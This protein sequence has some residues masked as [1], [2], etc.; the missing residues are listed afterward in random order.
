MHRASFACNRRAFLKLAGVGTAALAFSAGVPI[1]LGATQLSRGR[2]PR[3][4]PESQ[5]VSSAGILGFLDAL[6]GSKHEFHSF[7]MLRH[8][9]VIAEGWWHP[10]RPNA[11]HMLYSLSKSFTSTAVG[12]AVAEG[13]LKVTDPVVS[14]FADEKPAEISENLSKLQVRHL[15]SMSVGHG[16]DS[17]GSLWGKDDWVKTF[18]SLPIPHEPGT[19]FLY[20]SGATYMCSAIVQ[21]VTGQRLLDYLESRLFEPL[22]IEGATWETCPRGVNT[23]G[24]GLK[25]P[26]ESLAKFGQLLLQTGTWGD[27][28]LLP[29]SWIEEATTAKI[30]QPAPDLEQARKRSDW[31]QGYGYQFWRCRHNAYRG[32]GAFGQYTIVLPDQDA[33]IAITSESPSM[34]GQL[35]LVYE[36]LLPAIKAAPLP[37]DSS[38]QSALETR[39]SSLALV[40]ARSLSSAPTLASG[41]SGMPFEME[42]NSLGIESVIFDFRPKRCVFTALAEAKRHSIRCGIGSYLDGE[43]A[44]PGTPPKLTQGDLGPVSKVTACAAWRD[45]STLEM[46]WR[47]YES[48]HHDR[49]VCRFAGDAV[50]IEFLNSMAA[51][52]PNPKDRRPVLKG[53]LLRH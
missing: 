46:T 12:F 22:R 53:R 21:K 19:Q 33:V 35:D 17:T 13:R 38:A 23:G 26:T 47:F 14:F 52:S 37:K 6:S 30:Q 5:G 42:S 39:L 43:T 32:D 41:I 10:Y 50:E 48:P 11:P 1:S 44:M 18:L 20:N 49:V 15:L 8:G 9:R 45:A 3:A 24:W 36:H 51:M 16:Q 4:T 7:M 40:P 31:H 27:R 34:Q 28:Q 29:P 25:L 2:L